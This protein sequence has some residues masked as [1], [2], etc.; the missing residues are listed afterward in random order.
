MRYRQGDLRCPDHTNRGKGLDG[1]QPGGPAGLQKTSLALK[2]LPPARGR[3]K[4]IDGEKAIAGEQEGAI[5]S[6]PTP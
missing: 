4:S 1:P 6:T 3:E 5:G 2:V